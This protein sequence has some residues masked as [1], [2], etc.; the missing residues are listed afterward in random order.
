MASPRRPVTSTCAVRPRRYA[1][2]NI[3]LGV[4]NRNAVTGMAT[5]RP[6]PNS[7]S[8]GWSTAR[9]NRDKQNEATMAATAV[10]AYDRGRPGT[11]R[12]YTAPMPKK[13][14]A[15]VT[16]AGAEYPSQLPMIGT[17]YGRGRDK[18]K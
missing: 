15:A 17:P 5:P 10:F 16:V 1:T 9:Y 13:V 7:T 6:T 18:P 8:S 4:K 14:S 2:G 11:T 3:S 12:Q